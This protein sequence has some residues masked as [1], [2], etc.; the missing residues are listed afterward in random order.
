MQL[1]RD[2]VSMK[3]LHGIRAS[4]TDVAKE[5]DRISADAGAA[6]VS[7]VRAHLPVHG[8]RLRGAHRP[9]RRVDDGDATVRPEDLAAVS[10]KLGIEIDDLP[11]C[12]EKHY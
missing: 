6:Q 9:H 7:A 11:F 2:G 12:S 3:P 4:V 1:L 10:G 5:R 8:D